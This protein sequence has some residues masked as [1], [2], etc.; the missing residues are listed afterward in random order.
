VAGQLHYPAGVAV[1]ETEVFV[2]DQE[3]DRTDVFDANSGAF[4]RAFGKNVNPDPAATNHDLCTTTTTC[5]AG[6]HG[7]EAGQLRY[8]T[9]VAVSGT[10]VFVSDGDNN[11]IDVFD[12]GSGEF[13]LAFGKNVN[14]D[15]AATNR[16]L[17]T[18]ATTCRIGDP[19]GAAGQFNYPAGVAVSK[20]EVFVVDQVNERIDVYS[21]PDDTTAPAVSL[22]APADGTVTGDSSP[23]FSGTGGTAA[24]DD[25]SATVEIWSGSSVGSGAPD[26]TVSATRDGSTGAYSTSGPFTKVSDS[27]SHATLPDGT[28]TARALQS[29]AASNVGQS[30]QTPTFTIDTVKPSSAA[31]SPA[32]T[33][34][35]SIQVGY[36]AND[37]GSGL[38]KVE[39]YAKAPGAGSF[40]KV[41]TDSSPAAS[42]HNFTYTPS[43]G[44]GAY[45]FYTVAY[46]KA[47]NV[48][49]AP[50]SADS[51]TTV[52]TAKPSSSASAA[53]FANNTSVEVSYTADG[54]GSPLAK[55]ELYVRGPSDVASSKVDTDSS[56]AGSGH[57]FSYAA[58]E[59]DG[60]Y[61]FYTRA[62]DRAG[63]VED[64]PAT[65]DAVTVALDTAKPTSSASSPAFSSTSSIEVAYTADGTGSALDK[66]ELYAKVPGASSYS[67]VDTDSSP[68]ASGHHFTYTPGAGDGVYAFYT[69]AYDKAGNVEDAPSGADSTTR[70]DTAAPAVTLT[71][72]TNGTITDDS[73]PEF[74]GTGGTATGDDASVTVNIWA[75][76]SVGKRPDYTVSA[77]RDGSTGAYSTSGPYTKV[78]DSSSVATLPHG[79]YTA[80]AFQ[81]DA[82]GNGA[83]SAQTTFTI[84]SAPVAVNDS[85]STAEDTALSKDAAHGVLANDTDA[86]NDALTAVLVSGP[87]HG[88]LTLNPDGSYSYTP[89][90]NYNGPDS[91]TYKANDGTSDSASSA[92]VLI[93]VT[94]VD[95]PPS[96]VNDTATVAQDGSAATI[97]VLAND[98][99]P[100]GGAKAIASKTNGSHGTVA[101]THS[102]A[103]LTY[104][105]D[106]GYCNNQTGDPAETFTYT[107]N[108]GST[109][110][111]TVKV[112]CTDTDGDGTPDRSDPD[113]DGDGVPNSQDAFPRDPHESVDTDGD[114]IGNKADADD[115]NDGVP[116]TQ[117]SAPLDPTKGRPN[118]PSDPPGL[119]TRLAISHRGRLPVK[120]AFVMMRLRCT[121]AAD[122]RCIGTLMLDPTA[123]KTRLKAAAARGRYG[124]AKFNIPAGK[125]PLIR[126]KATTMLLKDLRARHHLITLVSANYTGL[127]GG[128][129]RVERKLTLS[130]PK[131]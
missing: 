24:G 81:S 122:A 17:C 36:T 104:K 1:S 87:A 38:D 93:D 75:G 20:T 67:K 128:A 15:P 62:T 129:L 12:A 13:K 108:G 77:T 6:D 80:R 126:V 16:D 45:A 27:S 117:D 74:A 103:D 76:S 124:T 120:N 72:P 39:L 96:A 78:S 57:H 82:A 25:G 52:D 28:Y 111:V 68:A 18:T 125:S 29:D 69:V 118:G 123:G 101:I 79:T 127:H 53:A 4:K 89:V 105:P 55:V 35:G 11:R 54:T 116:D 114:G 58:A 121:G 64:A 130:L 14:P 30:T 61:A 70:V 92:T 115:D 107:L 109:A 110:T 86:D 100:D 88:S 47:G 9:G 42:G 23:E 21:N 60:N 19:G 102:G 106:P 95:D 43:A 10:Q 7:R 51:T 66:V 131:H 73:S 22:T 97:D 71:A 46:D 44:D 32:F 113:I 112:T 65:P 63:N 98:T 26:Y 37:A 119:Q 34:G 40:S 2:S 84:D 56:P 5:Q 49:D 50:A 8:P 31:S 3:N 33:N 41:D 85:G 59:G 91:F 94:A 48:E 90:G 99:D 83:Q